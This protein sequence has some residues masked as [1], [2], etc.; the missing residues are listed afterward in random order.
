MLKRY[1]QKIEIDVSK[2]ALLLQ[3]LRK[4]FEKNDGFVR[5]TLKNLCRYNQKRI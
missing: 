2:S 4:T 1:L 3:R 5:G